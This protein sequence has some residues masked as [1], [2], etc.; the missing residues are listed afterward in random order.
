M[1]PFYSFIKYNL[2][3]YHWFYFKSVEFKGESNVLKDAGVLFVVNH[4]NAFLDAMLV[5]TPLRK[6]LFFLVRSDVFKG[7]LKY[8]LKVFNLIPIYRSQDGYKDGLKRNQKIFEK[9]TKA[10]NKEKNILI[11][12][13]GGSRPIHQITPLKKGFAR[14]AMSYAQAYKKP[15]YIVPVSINYEHH[16]QPGHRVWV[17]YHSAIKID[18]QKQS[19]PALTQELTKVFEENLIHL[20]PEWELIENAFANEKVPE[21]GGNAKEAEG[22][23]FNDFKVDKGESKVLNFLFSPYL[24]LIRMILSVVNDEDF[25]GS[26][27]YVMGLAIF[28]GQFFFWLT[29]GFQFYPFF[30]IGFVFSALYLIWLKTWKYID[31]R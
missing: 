19:V 16:F 3:W 10:L 25:F 7:I 27:V 18:K 9:C 12:P 26:I 23:Y 11:F 24:W 22:G 13:E 4:Q 2:R 14:I 30:I 17:E 5:G 29:L 1:N 21:K 31:F 15:M 6:N 20:R 8:V 28:I